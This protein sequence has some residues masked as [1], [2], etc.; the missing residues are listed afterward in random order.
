MYARRGGRQRM[1]QRSDP[2]V[3]GVGVAANQG[4]SRALRGARRIQHDGGRARRGQLLPIAR[5]GDERE[6]ARIGLTE[7]C[8]MI[9]AHVGIAAQLAAKADRELP[10]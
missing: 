3:G 8:D 7:R 10:E 2:R 1:Q 4:G 5:I 9:H 6:R